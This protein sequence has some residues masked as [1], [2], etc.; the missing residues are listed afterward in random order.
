MCN[1]MHAVVHAVVHVAV[2]VAVQV[3]SIVME[4]CVCVFEYGHAFYGVCAL[5]SVCYECMW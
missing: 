2:Q 5:W 3:K 1:A 4:C